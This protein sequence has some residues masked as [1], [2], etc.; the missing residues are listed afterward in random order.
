VAYR[1]RPLT[2]FKADYP[3]WGITRNIPFIL[4]EMFEVN[5]DRWTRPVSSPA[6]RR[7]CRSDGAGSA[8]TPRPTR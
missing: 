6:S 4:N 3:D 8:R 5:A 2:E 1:C 7:F